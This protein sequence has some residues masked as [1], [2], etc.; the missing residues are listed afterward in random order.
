VEGRGKMGWGR[1][2]R[3]REGKGGQGHGSNGNSGGGKYA[4]WP[5]GGMDAP[6]T[7]VGEL[8]LV[9]S[10]R[11]LM[12]SILPRSK[13][14]ADN[15]ADFSGFNVVQTSRVGLKLSTVEFIT[16]SKRLRN[17]CSNCFRTELNLLS[18]MVDDRCSSMLIMN[19]TTDD[20]VEYL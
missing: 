1:K 3:R 14:F 19:G 9:D 2:G 10:F 15:S 5:L 8:P 20:D 4:S 18:D 7:S 16:V 13:S 6:A 12:S 17:S 11:N